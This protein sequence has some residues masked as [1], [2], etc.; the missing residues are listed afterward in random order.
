VLLESRLLPELAKGLKRPNEGTF[1]PDTPSLLLLSVKYMD[2]L[3]LISPSPL[4]KAANLLFPAAA[5]AAAEVAAV[6]D[7]VNPSRLVSLSLVL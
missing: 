2:C 7:M 1:P 3:F 6:A 5:V 4:L